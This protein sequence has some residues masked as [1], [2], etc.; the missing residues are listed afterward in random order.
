LENDKRADYGQHFLIDHSTISK[1]IE[2]CDVRK[3]D[4]V[5]EF[6]T[7]YGY[8]TKEIS[9]LAK[10]VYSFEI[11]KE[12]YSKAKTYLMNVENI[13]IFNEDFF[14]HD[15]FVF[16]FF[17]SNIPYSRSKEI[18]K[19][20]SLHEFREA[21]IMVQKEFSKKLMASPGNA[22]YSVVTVL[23]QYCFD[24]E[25]L[26]EVGKDSFL[27]PPQIQS[28]VIRLKSKQKKMTKDIIANLEYLFSHR[29]KNVVSLLNNRQ[30]DNK[31]IDELNIETLV[32][33]SN[34]LNDRENSSK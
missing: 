2:L 12:L 5:L 10:V 19:W 11:D 9:K 32:K 25:P 24:I 23:T 30:Y 3:K 6:G 18:M 4:T 1:I 16:D 29:N 17:L 34:V 20:L 15:P 22:K 26:F 14:A 7:G 27:P 13:R 8:L 28:T 21:V 33:I 31:R